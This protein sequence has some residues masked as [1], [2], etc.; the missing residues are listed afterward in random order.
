MQH[1]A[2][3][4]I[5][6]ETVEIGL[7][8]LFRSAIIALHAKQFANIKLR[9]RVVLSV[10]GGIAKGTKCACGIAVAAESISHL[11][12]Y[13]APAFAVGW[14]NARIAFFV[15]RCGFAIFTNGHSGI[16]PFD[17]AFGGAT[18]G[19]Q[20]KNEENIQWA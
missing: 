9:Q 14:R 1:L 17:T 15:L 4:L 19:E 3:A 12:G 2:S 8:S 16:A 7:V 11:I 5:A 20:Y 13:F 18:G 10:T 6:W